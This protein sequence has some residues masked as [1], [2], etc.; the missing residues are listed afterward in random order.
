MSMSGTIQ[1]QAHASASSSSGVDAEVTDDTG[2]PVVEEKHEAE[3]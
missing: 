3:R 1:V 2:V